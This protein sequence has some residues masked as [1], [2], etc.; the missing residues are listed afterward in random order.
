MISAFL[1][2]MVSPRSPTGCGELIHAL[3]HFCVSGGVQSA[4]IGEQDVADPVFFNFDLLLKPGGIEEP[5]VCPVS[6]ADTRTMVVVEC[7]P[8]ALL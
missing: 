6:V 5:S 2:L 4:T 8:I 7:I 3:L 1:V